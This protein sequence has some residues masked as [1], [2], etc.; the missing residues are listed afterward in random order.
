MRA[1][2]PSNGHQYHY[3]PTR[4]RPTLSTDDRKA[5]DKKVEK[6][7][8][9]CKTETAVKKNTD[10]NSMNPSSQAEENVV[11]ITKTK[12]SKGETFDKRL[13]GDTSEKNQSPD[14]K[15]HMSPKADSS[16]KKTQNN[17]QDGE[18]KKGGLSTFLLA[19]CS[20]LAHLD[21][22]HTSLSMCLTESAACTSAA[23]G[24]AG[25]TNAEEAT[26][27][28]AERRRQARAQK[29]LEEKKRE[30]EEDEKR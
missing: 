30:E 21:D 27:L 11:E 15:D 5:E 19:Q 28:L 4:H 20:V 25:T 3:S 23:K 29:E 18:K 13:K 1:Q 2:S 26:R 9:Q 14:R 6:P 22:S 16:E 24:A 10:I 7:S 12:S 8:E 17:V